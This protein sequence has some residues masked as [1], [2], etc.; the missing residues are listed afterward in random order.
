MTIT[1]LRIALSTIQGLGDF[2]TAEFPREHVRAEQALFD[3]CVDAGMP[4]DHA[5]PV[6]WAETHIHFADNPVRIS[7][8]WAGSG[9][10]RNYSMPSLEGVA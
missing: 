10:A 5:N 9:Y 8:L 1:A 3:A 7:G 4:L 6:A 2:E